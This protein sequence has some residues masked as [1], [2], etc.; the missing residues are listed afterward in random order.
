VHRSRRVRLAR[1]FRYRVRGRE[2]RSGALVAAPQDV[3]VC[4]LSDGAGLDAPV[5]RPPRERGRFVERR[6]TLLVAP[7]SRMHEGPAKGEERL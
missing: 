4:E 6:C 1:L 5:T 3:E 2:L 7:P